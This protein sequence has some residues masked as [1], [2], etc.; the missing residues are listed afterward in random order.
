[1]SS[2]KMQWVH[3]WV[4]K[5]VRTHCNHNESHTECEKVIVGQVDKELYC[6]LQVGV[7]FLPACPAM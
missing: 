1:M 7:Q 6:M 2:S 3:T 5:T 4:G